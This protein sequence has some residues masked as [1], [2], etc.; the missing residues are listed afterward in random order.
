VTFGFS[1]AG[2]SAF[3][4]MTAVIAHRGDVVSG[5]GQTLNQHFAVSRDDRIV[6][7]ASIDFKIYPDGITGGGGADISGGFTRGSAQ[8]L[9]TLLQSAPLAVPLTPR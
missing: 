2:A 7:V 5:F 3:Q 9:G 1:D 6:M 4:R 8:E